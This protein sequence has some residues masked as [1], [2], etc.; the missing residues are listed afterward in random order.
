M[1]Q[2]R[3]RTL[4]NFRSIFMQSLGHEMNATL[5]IERAGPNIAARHILVPIC[6]GEGRGTYTIED[7]LA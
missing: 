1:R 7:C 6:I 5:R 4:H 3:R 2:I